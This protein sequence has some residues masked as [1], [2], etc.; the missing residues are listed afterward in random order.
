M[1]VHSS[2]HRIIVTTEAGQELTIETTDADSLRFTL[3]AVDEPEV[4]E[5]FYISGDD[6]SEVGGWIY[7]WVLAGMEEPIGPVAPH[8]RHPSVWPGNN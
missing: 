2:K 5:T 7:G 4:R 6:A 1:S 8:P 3:R